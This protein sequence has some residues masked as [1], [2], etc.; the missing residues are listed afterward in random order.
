MQKNI[1]CERELLVLHKTAYALIFMRITNEDTGLKQLAQN[2]AKC[3]YSYLFVSVRTSAHDQVATAVIS[4]RLLADVSLL[5]AGGRTLHWNVLHLHQSE[6][7]FNIYDH[8]LQCYDCLPWMMHR[9]TLPTF[10][11]SYEKV[12]LV[13]LVVNHC[14]LA[15]QWKQCTGPKK[16]S[17]GGSEDIGSCVEAGS[18][19]WCRHISFM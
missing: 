13:S 11:Y 10:Y 5:P 6:I 14:H 19:S 2:N 18:L 1:L 7:C 15:L 12:R 17:S 9:L 3:W 8:L 4:K 16:D